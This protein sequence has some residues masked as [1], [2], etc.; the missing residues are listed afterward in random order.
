MSVQDLIKRLDLVEKKSLELESLIENE[1][2]NLPKIQKG[3][4]AS[5]VSSK[6]DISKSLSLT[7]TK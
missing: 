3:K 6:R 4:F 7:Q 5:E 1:L 2:E